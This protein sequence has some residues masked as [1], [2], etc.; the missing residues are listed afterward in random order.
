[1]VIK[2]NEFKWE[3]F[4]LEYGNNIIINGNSLTDIKIIPDNVV[5]CTIT[6]PPYW[7]LRAYDK[8][9]IPDPN[10][11]G[12]EETPDEYI[13][14]LIIVF[15]EVNRIT[16]PD[17][18]LY[19]NLGDTYAGGCMTGTTGPNSTMRKSEER[20][21]K[22][23]PRKTPEGMKK[24][25][26]VGI[27]WLVAFALRSTGW[28]FRSAI[29]LRKKMFKPQPQVKDRP[30]SGY[31]MAF[32]L[33]KSYDCKYYQP[34]NPSGSPKSD[35]WDITP[36][37]GKDGHPAPFSDDFVIECILSGT[38]P[39]DIIFDPFGGMNTVGKWA[40]KF[41]RK[42]IVFELLPEYCKD[43]FNSGISNDNEDQMGLN[44]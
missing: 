40:Y 37:K 16:K 29:V 13:K 31:E 34:K 11:I 32:L 24:K 33:S 35:V 22:L 5:Q 39:D 18:I 21:G 38:D 43:S 6:S 25:D 7:G 15:N 30:W 28:Y 10:E 19:L 20:Y 27:P 26:L 9:Q 42:S 14:K 23:P 8:D 4:P 41:K 44:I 3:K 1:M 2:P 36:G 17:G 12:R